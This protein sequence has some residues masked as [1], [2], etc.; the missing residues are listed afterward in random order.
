MS[1]ER[2]NIDKE[3]KS[4]I[5]EKRIL[6]AFGNLNIEK[7]GNKEVAW[8]RFSKAVDTKK[9]KPKTIRRIFN[10]F[11]VAASIMVLVSLS[12]VFFFQ[13]FIKWSIVIKKFTINPGRGIY[14]AIGKILFRAFV[15]VY[16]YIKR[17][18]T[19]KRVTRI[20]KL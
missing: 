4:L 16:I 13:N 15:F 1:K 9:Q 8:E 19:Y 2:R 17:L 14:S 5:V 20:K 11:S 10:S 18:H 12:I 6:D 3:K 7:E